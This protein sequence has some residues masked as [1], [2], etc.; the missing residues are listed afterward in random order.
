MAYEAVHLVRD[1]IDA[2]IQ[3]ARDFQCGY[4]ISTDEW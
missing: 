1:G 3:D 2:G 4:E